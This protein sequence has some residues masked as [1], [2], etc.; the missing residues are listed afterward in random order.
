MPRPPLHMEKRKDTSWVRPEIRVVV[1]HLRGEE[2]LRHATV[3]RIAF[4][5]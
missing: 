1:Q 3:K 4:L 2:M 5:P